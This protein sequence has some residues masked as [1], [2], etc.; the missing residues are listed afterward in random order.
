MISIRASSLAEL[1]DC[2]AR[3]E[4]KHILKM[5][6]PKSGAAQL[7][8]AVHA[9]TAVYDQ[10]QIDRTGITID[11]AA[12]AV[13]DSIVKPEE[14]VAWDDDL[15]A[16]AAMKI[17]LALHN[18]YCIEVTPNMNYA[19]VEVPCEALEIPDLGLTLT[20]TTD[21]VYVD[22]E[23]R[24]GIA[25]LKTGARAVGTDGRASTSGHKPQMGVY[26]LLASFAIQKP[27]SA[28]AVIVGL[29]TGT[30]VQRVGT[31]E[32]YNAAH[33]L[34]GNETEPGMLEYASK[35]IHSGLFYGNSKSPLCS[36]KYCPRYAVCKYK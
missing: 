36:A 5:S 6:T 2:P 14:D 23:G 34:L 28:P 15:N 1:F 25:D 10:A 22:A 4:A 16:N 12:G 3:W 30:K 31:G 17:A 13:V 29:Q 18:K 26:E 21:R 9:G 27:I 24:Y 19:G 32:I 7:G 33:A 11:E 20:G 8:T 35:I